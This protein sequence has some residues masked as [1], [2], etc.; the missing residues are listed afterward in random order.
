MDLKSKPLSERLVSSAKI[1]AKH[2]ERVPV[3]VSKMSKLNPKANLL[4]KKFIC[5]RS[6]TVGQLIYIIRRFLENLSMKQALFLTISDTKILPPTG[7][8]IGDVYDKYKDEDGF[9]YCVI[10]TENVFG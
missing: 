5:P 6:L 7:D 2:P 1:I 3:I 9:L 10:Y 8:K 4:R